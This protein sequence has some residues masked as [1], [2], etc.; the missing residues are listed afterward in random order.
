MPEDIEKMITEFRDSMA[1]SNIELDVEG[2]GELRE[3][4]TEFSKSG[5][6]K[7]KIKKLMKFIVRQM[8]ARP[9][10]KKVIEDFGEG[11]FI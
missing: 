1:E 9:L 11:V 5:N 7:E 8:I 4:L 2:T 10:V 3:I 6:E